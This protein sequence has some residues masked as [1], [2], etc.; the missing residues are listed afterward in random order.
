VAVARAWRGFCIAVP[1]P[2]RNTRGQPVVG[3]DEGAD[4]CEMGTFS[5]VWPS[6]QVR[7]PRRPAIRPPGCL[8]A[9]RP[10]LRRGGRCAGCGM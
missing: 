4:G 3:Y 5:W 2:P 6:P 1:D 9:P 10:Q 8:G 7:A